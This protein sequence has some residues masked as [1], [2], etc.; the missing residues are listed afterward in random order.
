MKQK[1]C[2]YNDSKTVQRVY[3]DTLAIE[4]SVLLQPLQLGIFDVEL[5]EGEAIWVK[6][7]GYYVLIA[8]VDKN[9]VKNLQGLRPDS[10][11]EKPA[12]EG[13]K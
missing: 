12:S 10:Q 8:K 9:G 4:N 3:V 2:Y 13:N 5:E 7:W 1:V 11:A 6:T